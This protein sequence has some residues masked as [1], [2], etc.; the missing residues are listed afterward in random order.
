MKIRGKGPNKDREIICKEAKEKVIKLPVPV[1]GGKFL[2]GDGNTDLMSM[3]LELGE[4]GMLA[5][6]SFLLLDA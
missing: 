3:V 5:V 6:L 1:L 4:V 2:P